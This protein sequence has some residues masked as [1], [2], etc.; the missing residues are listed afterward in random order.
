MSTLPSPPPTHSLLSVLSPSSETTER[1]KA[2]VVATNGNSWSVWLVASSAK[3]PQQPT[4]AIERVIPVP[5]SAIFHMPTTVLEHALARDLVLEEQ[6]GCNPTSCW[7]LNIPS[8]CIL[9][10]RAG[11][12]DRHVYWFAAL[13][14]GLVVAVPRNVRQEMQ[15]EWTANGPPLDV[16]R[17]LARTFVASMHSGTFAQLC[18]ANGTPW[19]VTTTVTTT[20]VPRKAPR[21]SAGTVPSTSTEVVPLRDTT[22]PVPR[23]AISRGESDLLR[24]T[25]DAQRLRDVVAV[26]KGSMGS[27]LCAIRERMSDPLTTTPTLTPPSIRSRAVLDEMDMVLGAYRPISEYASFASTVVK[28]SARLTR[29]LLARHMIEAYETRI[30]ERRSD[31]EM[32]E[33]DSGVFARLHASKRQEYLEAG[34]LSDLATDAHRVA[35]DAI[36]DDEGA[37]RAAVALMEHAI[38]SPDGVSQEEMSDA[39]VIAETLRTTRRQLWEKHLVDFARDLGRERVTEL[40]TA[41]WATQEGVPCVLPGLPPLPPLPPLPSLPPLPTATDV[42]DAR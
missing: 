10:V 40:L 23:V 26:E 42:E 31:L 38:R 30:L 37:D 29:P 20:T 13:T 18:D 5:T 14:G 1:R 34:R 27:L 39:T 33:R 7:P 17:E 4:G 15:G 35:A 12:G 9:G 21:L 24:L 11:P 3:G 32:L 19:A 8:T 2:H 22:R 41:L 6:S 28:R 25:L 36:G 16:S